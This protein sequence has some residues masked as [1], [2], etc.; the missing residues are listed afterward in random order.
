MAYII[1]KSDGTVLLTVDD[2]ILNTS[3]SLGL[4]GRN[5]TGYGEIQNE[6]FVYLL[7]N[8]SNSNPPVRPLRGQSWYDSVNGRM[9]VYTGTEWAPVSSAT[10]SESPPPEFI[11]SLWLRPSSKQLSIYNG[12]V[13]VIIGPE[14]VPGFGETRAMSSILKDINNIDHAV[15]LMKVNDTVQGIW[16]SEGFSINNS[17]PVDGFFQL[18]KGLNLSGT[19]TIQGNLI[20]NASTADKL[21]VGK[22]I[23]GVVFDGSSD[24][25][26]TANTTNSLTRGTYLTGANF[27]GASP[28]TWSVDASPT[29]GIG[30]V[31]ARDNNGSFAANV[32]T[33][34]N[35]VGTLSGNVN[36]TTGTSGFN[37]IVANEVDGKIFTGR[38]ARASR[39]DVGRTINNVIFDGSQNIIVPASAETL[40][41]ISINNNVT[42]SN[43]EQ[44]GVLRSLS[45]LDQGIVVGTGNSIQVSVL[46][47]IPT[48]NATGKID[49]IVNNDGPNL[50]FVTPVDAVS[51]GGPLAPAILS[52]NLTNL[53]GPTKKFDNV[54]AN[55]FLGNAS[56]ASVLQSNRTING[57]TF[58]GSQNIVIFDNTK[59]SLAGG[60]VTGSLVI[61]ESLTIPTSS[62]TIG[63]ANTLSIGI[64][65]G[66]PSITS[67]SEFNILVAG[68]GPN[69]TFATAAIAA[70]AGGPS[71]PAILSNNLTNLG[72]PNRKFNNIYA[73]NL[74]G[75]SNS[76]TILQ[77]GRTINGVLFNGSQNITIVDNTKLPLTGGT[78]S[79]TLIV[80][81]P[82][83]QSQAPTENNHLVNK[84]YVDNSRILETVFNAGN[85]GS[86]LTLNWNNGTIQ[87]V[88]ANNNF[89][90]A[91]PINMPSG[92]SLTA[93]IT[94][95]SSGNRRLTATSG[96]VFASGFKT[97]ST[98]PN[99][100]DMINI[101][102]AG[103]IY[104]VTLT[105]GYV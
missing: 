83:V 6:N 36:I 38:A 70:S 68:S 18:L 14:A 103:S 51:Q 67:S 92:G 54:Y 4:L 98:Q 56:S 53:G 9:N 104:F 102:R 33:A 59:L 43:L 89:T 73:N 66:T 5:Y 72:G 3:T 16:C 93:I 19:S 60:T 82:I 101:F 48:I 40:T 62:L 99:A 55:S 45:I 74:I 24:I 69:I 10:I 30:T 8:F 84:L 28:T 57:V 105:T 52:N 90:L 47:N 13:W 15:I 29:T 97:L 37:N 85:T 20:G 75:N 1:N 87:I 41:G 46:S 64:T 63:T 32:I 34:V 88:L 39:L 77:T 81:S 58:N 86:S 79:G 91:L 25:T 26:F 96:Y 50:S 44:V 100:V 80:N 2:G 78:I 65:S 49:I 61:T 42:T 35:F 71:E 7:E 21:T 94:Q 95:D 27:N 31:V 11:G 17:N 12:T 23:N 76:A 22:T